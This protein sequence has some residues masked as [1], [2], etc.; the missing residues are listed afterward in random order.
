M[1]GIDR[2]GDRFVVRLSSGRS[3][4]ARAVVLATGSR[5]GTDWAPAALRASE[6]LVADP[7][8]QELPD[9]DLLLVGTGLTM[10]DVAISADRARAAPLHTV[11][12]HDLRAR[13]APAADDPGRAAAPGHHPHRLAR[14]AARAVDAHVERT[15][16]ETG[17]WRAAI[18]GLRPVTAQLWKGLGDEDKRRLPRRARP[19][20]GRPPP[21][22]VAGDRRAAGRRSPTPA[23]CSGTPAPWPT[24]ATCP[25]ASR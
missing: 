9:G 4:A 25:A 13:G 8:T 20:L 5:P 17:D 19:H 23:G 2:R 18:D 11:S 21:P 12:R 14:R 7:W 24:P 6:R 10:V 16:E 1:I 3:T 22:D 15:V